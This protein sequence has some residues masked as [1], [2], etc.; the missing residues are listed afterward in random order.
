MAGILLVQIHKHQCVWTCVEA[1]WWCAQ[2]RRLCVE[3][4]NTLV[5]I[6]SLLT[7]R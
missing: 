3:S 5:G 6:M 2:M 4:G 1:E 7:S